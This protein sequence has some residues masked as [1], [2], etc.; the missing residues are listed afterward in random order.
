MT[1]EDFG[2]KDSMVMNGIPVDDT[3]ARVVM[4][5]EKMFIEWQPP[6]GEII[7]MGERRCLIKSNPYGECILDFAASYSHSKTYCI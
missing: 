3:I 7:A 4:P 1:D 6:D 5:F 2:M